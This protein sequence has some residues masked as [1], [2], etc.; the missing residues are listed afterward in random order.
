M[1]DPI[2]VVIPALL[3]AGWSCSNPSY[4]AG[5]QAAGQQQASV[6][7]S[8]EPTTWQTAQ[9]GP[10]PREPDPEVI[11]LIDKLAEIS[12]EDNPFDDRFFADEAGSGIFGIFG[13]DSGPPGPPPDPTGPVRQLVRMGLK[14]LPDLID[15]LTD[16]R[17]TG[18]VLGLGF[19]EGTGTVWESNKYDPRYRDPKRWPATVS[20]IGS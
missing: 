20:R 19:S 17:E 10:E 3:L 5:S 4:A 15:H 7:A 9:S 16:S 11:A 18:I 2:A 12:A 1:I 6:G 8:G 13:I 14:A